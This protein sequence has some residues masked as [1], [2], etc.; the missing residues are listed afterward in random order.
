M[1][2]RRYG[3]DLRGVIDR[4]DSLVDLGVNAIYL[5]PINDSPSLHKYAARS[6]RH[7]DRN[8]AFLFPIWDWL[9]GTLYLPREPEALHFGLG[10]G[11]EADYDGVL[12]LYYLP[13]L[14]LF[15]RT[16]PAAHTKTLRS[17]AGTE[18]T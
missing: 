10:D 5:N 4:L 2:A 13:F 14:R 11:T 12:K 9:L 7:V 18:T 3:G 1:Q 17:R 8:F 15:Q 16:R 6:W